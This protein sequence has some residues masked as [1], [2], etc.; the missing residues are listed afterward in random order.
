M[1]T[2]QFIICLLLT[3][4]LY[5]GSSI[6]GLSFNPFDWKHDEARFFYC[7]FNFVIWIIPLIL[8]YQTTENK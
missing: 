4:M 1:K 8:N 7:V 5:L 2:N 3:V 6:I